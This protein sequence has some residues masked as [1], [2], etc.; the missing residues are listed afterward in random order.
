VKGIALIRYGKVETL[1]T[2][3]FILFCALRI[4][5]VVTG[6][7]EHGIIAGATDEVV[8]ARTTPKDVHIR[9]AAYII[10]A[11]AAEETIQASAAAMLSSPR[12]FSLITRPPGWGLYGRTVCKQ[13][14]VMGGP[15]STPAS[16]GPGL[17]AKQPMPPAH[18]PPGGYIAYPTPTR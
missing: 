13:M 15:T 3:E 16:F 5:N 6:T 1:A 17:W 4:E 18:A 9:P 14:F 11:V 10:G 7:A 12:S 2:V 8:A